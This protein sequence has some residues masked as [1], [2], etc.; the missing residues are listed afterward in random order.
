MGWP[1]NP[2]HPPAVL[3]V[4]R[5]ARRPIGGAPPRVSCPSNAPNREALGDPAERS[6]TSNFEEEMAVNLAQVPG[7][8]LPAT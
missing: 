1:E 4:M 3:Q 2:G 5:A 7:P 8:L 6:A